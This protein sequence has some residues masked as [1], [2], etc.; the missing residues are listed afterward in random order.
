M[1]ACGVSLI[2]SD[3]GAVDPFRSDL[4]LDARAEERQEKQDKAWD[5]WLD[6][7]TER[8]I[9]AEV[10][11]DEE[12]R[13]TIQKWL[14]KRRTEFANYQAPASLQTFD[15]WK[16]GKADESAGRPPFSHRPA[17]GKGTLY[18]PVAS[19]TARMIYLP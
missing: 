14:D 10:L 13:P 5:L 18:F 17:A 19:S 9:A 3:P 2:S 4:I 1:R 15:V 11:G 12:K 16:F 7:Y 8:E 6:C